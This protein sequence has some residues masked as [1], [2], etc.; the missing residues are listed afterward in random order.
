MTEQTRGGVTAIDNRTLRTL[1]PHAGSMCLLDTVSA[2][3]ESEITCCADSHR[4]ADNPL[5]V[6]GRLPIEAG[7]EYAA[8]AMAIHGSL[9]GGRDKGGAPRIGYLAVLSKVR[10]SVQHLDDCDSPLRVRA[11]RLVATADGSHYQFELSHR[12]AVLL[13]GQA[14]VALADS[15]TLA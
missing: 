13:S 1:L 11:T 14:V 2:W 7:I 9:C 6:D 5:A 3:D 8:Q 10:W 4:A 12:G 15:D